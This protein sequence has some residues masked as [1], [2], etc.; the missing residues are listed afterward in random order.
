MD[1]PQALGLGS[2]AL[3]LPWPSDPVF[4]VLVLIALVFSW[5][6]LL[7]PREKFTPWTSRSLAPVPC[8]LAMLVIVVTAQ[9]RHASEF[10]LADEAEGA[11]ALG[12]L[13]WKL[14]Q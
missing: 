11:F 4:P 3:G 7:D 12:S 9:V 1:E 8:D 10:S 6:R 2:F 13:P 5:E 14:H